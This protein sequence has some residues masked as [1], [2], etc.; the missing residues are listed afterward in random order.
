MPSAL[1]AL[2][3][4]AFPSIASSATDAEGWIDDTLHLIEELQGM[5]PDCFFGCSQ[6]E[7]D[8]AVDA[9]IGAYEGASESRCLTALMELVARLSRNGRDGHT[10][11]WP[12]RGHYLPFQVYGF[13]DG[14][15]VV[16]AD[17]EHDAWIG[18]RLDAVGDEPVERVCE[19][20][21]PLLTRDNEWN[22]RQKLGAALMCTELLDGVGLGLDAEHARVQLVRGGEPETLELAGTPA[23]GHRA[24]S[25]LRAPPGVRAPWLEGTEQAFRL[26]VL[27]PEHALYVQYNEVTERDASGK[28]LTDFATELVRVFRERGLERV[29]VDVR[30][31]GGGDNTTFGPLI[32]ALQTPEIDR[33]GVLFGLIGRQTFSAAGN[34]VTVL[35]RDTKAILV[36]EPT[37]GAPNQ[38]GDA[39][40][41]PLPNHPGVMVRVST[42]YHQFSSPDDARLTHEPNLAVPLR[43]E[44]YFAGQDPVL[45]AAIEYTPPR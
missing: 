19:R 28:S 23:G 13:V 32:A 2:S 4:L 14:W 11:V 20:L 37:G 17:D 8:A 9:C 33:Q 16:A 29:L 34:F 21:G 18:A 1:L 26:Q 36:G 25:H 43:S 12:A 39:R 42:R 27:E 45:R 3:L 5:H 10:M 41:V 7:F 40:D 24:L 31:N 6:E 30:S 38:Y 22:L 15:F 44:D 35:Q